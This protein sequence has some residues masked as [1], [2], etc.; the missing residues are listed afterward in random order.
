MAGSY[1]VI[2]VGKRS[3][4]CLNYKGRFCKFGKG[5]LLSDFP[6]LLLCNSRVNSSVPLNYLILHLSP[7]AIGIKVQ[8]F[9]ACAIALWKSII[10][11]IVSLLACE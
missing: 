7:S 4:L 8:E 5:D 10:C 6:L 9:F 1:E 2:S 3:Q 11:M